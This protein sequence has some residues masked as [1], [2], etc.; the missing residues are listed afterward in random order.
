MSFRH[1]Y[2]HEIN[3]EDMLILR[4]RLGAVARHDEH[5]ENGVNKIRSVYFDDGYDTAL[6]E[7]INGVNKREKFR[8][9]FYNDDISFIRL[10]KKCK[11]N[12]LCSKTSVMI[13]ADEAADIV[14]GKIDFMRDDE[15]EL[16]REL[17]CKMSAG[18][19]RAK[20]VVDYTREA[21]VY[22]AGN[23]RVTLDYDLRTGADTSEFLSPDCV[24][25]PVRDAP[26]I[27]EV[28]WDEFLPEI[29]RDAVNLTGR[30]SSAFSKYAAC[31]MYG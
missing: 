5:G 30:R 13:S 14:N 11:I 16:L 4:S 24:T 21:F 28:K 15:R 26:V 17:Y 3:T 27:L 6:M 9:R 1:E 23:V 2:K 22:P 25:L 8:I 18:S 20:T 29:I 7:K 12:G 19:L 31:R 10:E